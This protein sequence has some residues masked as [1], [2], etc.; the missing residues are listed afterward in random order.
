MLVKKKLKPKYQPNINQYKNI[1]LIYGKNGID[2]INGL[3]GKQG[4]QGIQGPVGKS[5]N[6]GKDGK[7]GRDG[8][9]GKDGRDGKDGIN[10]RGIERI[11]RFARV[12]RIFYTDGT[13]QDIPL[14]TPQGTPD[15][16]GFAGGGQEPPVKDIRAGDNITIDENNGIF[17]INANVQS[18]PED[19]ILYL[20]SI[21]PSTA[22]YTG[23]KI[24][25]LTY[26]DFNNIT[27]HTKTLTYTGNDLTQTVESF[28]YDS[29]TWTVTIDLAYS[30][31]VWQSKNVNIVKV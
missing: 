25:L 31:G 10:G 5:G 29:Q 16:P 12:M 1:K 8:V 19:S 9:D 4:I 22:T 2:G 15:N 11:E 24:T 21:A 18:I 27:S 28:V 26:D 30:S 6:D 20:A 14:S 3:D 23:E 13:S 7:S 17:T